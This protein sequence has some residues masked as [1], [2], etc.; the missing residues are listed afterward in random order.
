MTSPRLGSEHERLLKKLVLATFRRTAVPGGVVQLVGPDGPKLTVE[1]GGLGANDPVI[2]GSTSKSLTAA[3]LLQ[4]A[5]EGTI[6]LNT[7]ITQYL[8]QAGVPQDVTVVDLAHHCSGLATDATPGHMRL[9]RGR[10]FRYANQNYNLLGQVIEATLGVSFSGALQQRI[11]TPLA[12]ADSTVENRC[13][14]TAH[15][16]MSPRSEAD[17]GPKRADSC[18]ISTPAPSARQRSAERG[19][20]ATKASRAHRSFLPSPRE[21]VGHVSIFGF[22]LPVRD[23]PAGAHSWIQ[24]PSGAT[25]ASAADAGR[26]LSMLLNGGAANGQRFLSPTALHRMLHDVVPADGS[27]AVTGVLGESGEYGFG[28][29]RKRFRDQWVH[30]HVGK[31]PGSTT[32]FVLLPALQLGFALLVNIGDFLVRQPLVER[33]ADN[34]VRVLVGA[35]PLP[36]PNQWSRQVLLNA[37]YIALVGGAAAGARALPKRTAAKLTYHALLPASLAAGVRKLSATPWPWL[38]RFVPEAAAVLG[39]G[40]AASGIS[41]ILALIPGSS[42]ALKSGASSKLGTDSCRYT[43]SR[44]GT[45]PSHNTSGEGTP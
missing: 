19:V 26:F 16:A 12:M 24:A 13:P 43:A 30:L 18:G 14:E 29:I 9:A 33:L 44:T 25:Y 8:P 15:P 17:C 31:V 1:Y 34:I 23:F 20:S 7:P 36:I 45:H 11:L 35:P 28:W 3:L 37:T 32:V 10:A 4:L 22:P 2:L 38:L 21:P 42:S 40:A 39:A 27:P 5:E 6:D 41:G